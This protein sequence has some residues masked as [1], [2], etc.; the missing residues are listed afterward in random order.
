MKISKK[1]L[2]FSILYLAIGSEALSFMRHN[3]KINM[4]W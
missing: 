4:L 1:L 2:E 3:K